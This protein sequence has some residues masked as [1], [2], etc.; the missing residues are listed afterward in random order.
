M[1]SFIKIDQYHWMIHTTHTAKS[2]K[3]HKND[4]QR[5]QEQTRTQSLSSKKSQCQL[6]IDKSLNHLLFELNIDNR[7]NFRRRTY[8]C[9]YSSVSMLFR[10]KPANSKVCTDRKI[11]STRVK[12]NSELLYLSKYR[13]NTSPIISRRE[14]FS[15]NMNLAILYR[16]YCNQWVI[17]D[18]YF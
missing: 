2:A 18:T 1:L 17:I 8:E 3:S 14:W 15:I 7:R 6:L 5:Q 16:K 9:E 13:I 10:L 12:C 4:T 11:K